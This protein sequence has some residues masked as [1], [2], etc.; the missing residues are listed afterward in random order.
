MTFASYLWT[1]RLVWDVGF[2]A[3]NQAQHQKTV[4]PGAPSVS[5]N[6]Y[7]HLGRLC[8]D[9]EVT[10]TVWLLTMCEAYKDRKLTP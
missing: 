9:R 2:L 7:W 1:V 3:A 8:L 6:G 5:H 10:S 4:M